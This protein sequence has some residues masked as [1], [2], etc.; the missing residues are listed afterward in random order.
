MTVEFTV[1]GPP[2]GK[3]RPRFVRATGRT[4][5]PKNTVDFERRVKEAFLQAAPEGF[6]PYEKGTPLEVCIKSRFIPPKSVSKAKRSA[7]LMGEI[8]PTKVPDSDNLAKS[9]LDGMHNVCY[10]NDSSVVKLSVEKRYSLVEETVVTVR[11][12]A[13]EATE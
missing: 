8:L 9:V 13:K 12:I 4:Y 7:M 3:A 6:K 11:E 2:V 10:T 5:T 1:P